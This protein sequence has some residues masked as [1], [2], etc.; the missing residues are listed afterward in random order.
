M[1]AFS[2]LEVLNEKGLGLHGCGAK[3]AALN[4]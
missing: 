4:G 3:V 1:R 2:G